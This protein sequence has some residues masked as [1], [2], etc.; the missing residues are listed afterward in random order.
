[1]IQT[2]APKEFSEMASRM[3]LNKLMYIP[4]K[5]NIPVCLPGIGFDC[6]GFV[7][8]L[9]SLDG[10]NLPATPI[11]ARKMFKEINMPIY[12][13]VLMVRPVDVFRA[14]HVGFME[15]RDIV[16]HCSDTYGGV[17]RTKVENFI[18]EKSF[19]RLICV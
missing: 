3:I 19:Y 16:L 17:M 15:S 12:R 7:R 6:W 18:G 9:F 5:Y 11:A 10:I 8:Y 2:R 14:V 4:A 1:M 13:D